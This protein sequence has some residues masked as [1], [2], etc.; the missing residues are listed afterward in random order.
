MF[1]RGNIR[2]GIVSTKELLCLVKRK[3]QR[4]PHLHR[5]QFFLREP[6]QYIRFQ[7]LTRTRLIACVMKLGGELLRDLN[8]DG[9]Q[10]FLALTLPECPTV[11]R[12]SL[13]LRTLR[14]HGR[15]SLTPGANPGSSSPPGRGGAPCP[16]TASRKPDPRSASSRLPCGHT[17]RR[18]GRWG[19][20]RRCRTWRR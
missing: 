14:V 13:G 15:Q 10:K 20:P 17:R 16:R 7:K 6:L 18:C 2:R 9:H 3:P 4:L 5:G 19:R 12:D 8:G 1:L 11:S